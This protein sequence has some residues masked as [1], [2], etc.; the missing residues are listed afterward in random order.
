MK[1]RRR[2]LVIREDTERNIALVRGWQAKE[3]LIECGCKPMYSVIG[4]GWVV[5]LPRIPDVCAWLDYLSINYRF[6][7]ADDAQT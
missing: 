1:G 7:V 6:E 5:D 2:S 4:K 3:L